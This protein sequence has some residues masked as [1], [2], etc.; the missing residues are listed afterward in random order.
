MQ[1]LLEH[2]QLQHLLLAKRLGLQQQP[3]ELAE[4]AHRK[5]GPRC[6]PVAEPREE[7]PAQLLQA[8]IVFLREGILAPDKIFLLPLHA[9]RPFI[10]PMALGCSFL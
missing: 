6:I 4:V 5:V 9:Q 8:G 1:E 2:E 3:A 7:L 10:Q